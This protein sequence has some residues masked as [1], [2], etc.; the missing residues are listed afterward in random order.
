MGRLAAH[1]RKCLDRICSQGLPKS[2]VDF[3]DS[4]IEGSVCLLEKQA[5][6]GEEAFGLM[7]ARLWV[8]PAFLFRMENPPPGAQPDPSDREL[9]SR[10]SYF[11]WSSTPDTT[12]LT[13]AEQGTL[14]METTLRQQ[15]ERMLLSPKVR[16]LANEFATAWLQVYDLDL[17]DEKDTRRYPEFESMKAFMKEEVVRFFTD[18]FQNDRKVRNIWDDDRSFLNQELAAH[19]G[20]PFPENEGWMLCEWHAC[21]RARRH[22]W[23]CCHIG[24][25]LRGFTYQPHP[26]RTLDQ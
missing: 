4:I 9:A 22:P 18:L 25:T 24:T 19:Y 2:L 21:P 8:S 11:L 1:A 3:G 15:V 23:F 16:R 20:M 7:L 17:S 14:S 5:P 10:L 26:P 13:L 6:S 12:L